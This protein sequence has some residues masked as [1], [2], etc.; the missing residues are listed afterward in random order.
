MFCWTTQFALFLSFVVIF[1]NQ[2][3]WILLWRGHDFRSLNFDDLPTVELKGI[4][5]SLPQNIRS[6]GGFEVLDL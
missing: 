4:T 2:P 3:I 5:Q 6:E 1:Y